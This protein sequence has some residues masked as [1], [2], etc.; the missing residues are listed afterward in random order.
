MSSKDQ[1]ILRLQAELTK[2]QAEKS[3]L[4]KKAASSSPGKSGLKKPSKESLLKKH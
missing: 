1:D 4:K 3:S 2:L